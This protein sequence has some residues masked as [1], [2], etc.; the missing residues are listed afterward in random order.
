MRVH[1]GSWA[2]L[3]FSTPDLNISISAGHSELHMSK[4]R[5]FGFLIIPNR[6]RHDPT[7]PIQFGL[8]MNVSFGLGCTLVVANLYYCQPL[9]VQLS[10]HFS[11]SYS[12]VSKIPTLLQAGYCVG[13]LLIS[14]L[15]DLVRRRQLILLLIFLTTCITIGLSLT[16]NLKVFEILSFF[17]GVFNVTPQILLPFAAD[18]A[19]PEHRSAAVSV[20]QSGLMLGILL[21]RVL[22]GIIGNFTNWRVVYYMAI[23]VQCCMI[24]GAYSIIPDSPAKNHNLTYC[25]ILRSLM[26]YAVTEPKLIQAAL[27]NIASMACWSSFWVT[28]TFLLAGPPYNY[29]TLLI[30][31]MG[32]VGM[33]GIFTGPIVGR[34]IDRLVPWYATLVATLC[35]LVLQSI[36]T[37]AGGISIAAVV[38][39]C[40]GL[41]AFRQAQTVSLSTAIFSI[42]VEAR[43]RL[44]AVLTLSLFIGQVMGTSLGTKVFLAHG[45]RA[46][47][48]LSMAWY[49]WQLV[50]LFLRGPN[51]SRYT[52]F[53]YEGGFSAR[54]STP[55]TKEVASGTTTPGEPSPRA[56]SQPL[57]LH[58][59]VDTPEPQ[60][61]RGLE[62]V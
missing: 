29:S 45:W 41:D 11:V 18:L 7:K 34:I 3:S 27:I 4:T 43:A 57:P 53:G 22:S 62:T 1:D 56:I 26:K 39:F 16:K 60:E 2:C 52:W 15:G 17:L 23:G 28:L 49:G 48:A 54:K 10:D 42:S 59:P 30:G 20:V 6:L 55:V 51:C 8:F 44:N 19:P 9:L 61:R 58:Q 14:P 33:L 32:L 50:I 21:A 36:E 47:S 25:D 31:L 46:A 37:A 38:I 35:L 13:L 40:F 24:G 5:D 12:E